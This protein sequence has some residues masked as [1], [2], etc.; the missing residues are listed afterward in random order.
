[1]I[2]QFL[3]YGF[4]AP[5][6]L[7]LTNLALYRAFTAWNTSAAKPLTEVTAAWTA[8]LKKGIPIPADYSE[9]GH[10]RFIGEAFLTRPEYHAHDV[11]LK[12]R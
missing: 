1:M 9:M 2:S 11:A 12:R 6:V 4:G 3:T 10:G 7:V 5:A 8:F